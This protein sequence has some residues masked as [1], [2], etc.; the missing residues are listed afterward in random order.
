MLVLKKKPRDR[1]NENVS[2]SLQSVMRK[3]DYLNRKYGVEVYLC[4]RD[5]R[6]FEY[7]SSPSF[8]PTTLDVVSAAI[9]KQFICLP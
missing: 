3:L 4:A 2:R 6:V 5:K 9:F 8:H 7:S 1:R